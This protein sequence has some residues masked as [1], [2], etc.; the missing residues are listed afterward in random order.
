MSQT[1][2]NH[3][4]ATAPLADTHEH[5]LSEVE[6][7]AERPDVL[8][9]L[10]DGYAKA[11][12]I[13]AGA[14]PQ[15]VERMVTALDDDVAARFAPIAEAWR[16]IRFTGH[17]EVVARI[18]AQQWGVDEVTTDTL[19]AVQE[20]LPAKFEQG[21][22][23][24][25]L[26]EQGAIDHVQIDAVS[27]RVE[28]DPADAAFFRHDLSWLH[29]AAANFD[30]A[31]VHSATDITVR[32]LQMLRS[33]MEAL[34][35]RNARQAVAMKSQHAYDRPLTWQPREDSAAEQVLSRKLAGHELSVAEQCCLGDWCLA[36]GAELA[37][38]HGLPFKLHTGYLAGH[39]GMQ[40]EQVRPA[41][42]SPLFKAHPRTRFV[43]MHTG[44]PYG[45]EIIALAKHYPNVFIDLCWAWTIDPLATV[46]FVRRVIHAVPIN[47]LFAFGGDTTFPHGTLGYAAQARAGIAAALG[48]EIAAG[49]LEER[50]ALAIAGRIMNE[51]QRQFFCL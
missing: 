33:A 16:H 47:K 30:P 21:D 48:A 3:F 25:I 35:E 26:R 10:F 46:E 15:A 4:V 36:R 34:F 50:G 7:N 12:L 29:L 37:A 23:L 44:Y 42:L 45:G 1:D 5:L 40:L 27:W 20:R 39:S 49:F 28:P 6:F 32:D 38:E 18:A 14:D 43:L 17:G 19:T 22:R 41:H 11:D 13:V 51:N 2:L 31:A 9:L 24:R 8:R